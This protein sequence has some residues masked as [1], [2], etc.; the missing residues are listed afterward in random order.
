MWTRPCPNYVVLFSKEV[1]CALRLA[2]ENSRH[3]ATLPLV[4]RQMTGK[5]VVASPNVGCFLDYTALPSTQKKTSPILFEGRGRLCPTQVIERCY[6]GMWQGYLY[7]NPFRWR[8]D[9]NKTCQESLINYV[10]FSFSRITLNCYE[11]NE[12][13]S[14][15]ELIRRNTNQ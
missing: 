1:A 7:Q 11:S 3:L 12:P 10:I 5:P 8:Q 2:W 14:I 15:F 13:C 4:S 6:W 9:T